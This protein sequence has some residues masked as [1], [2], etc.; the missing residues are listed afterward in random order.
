MRPIARMR[1]AL[2]AIG[3]AGL[4]ACTVFFAVLSRDQPLPF[5][6][7]PRYWVAIIGMSVF[8]LGGVCAAL[9]S[10]VP[11]RDAVLRTGVFAMLSGAL[12]TAAASAVFMLRLSD[13]EVGGTFWSLASLVCLGS[14]SL[15]GLPAAALL[16]YFCARGFPHRPFWSLGAGAFGLVAFGALPVSISCGDHSIYHVV[17][18]H[19]FA[20]LSAGV[21]S[22]LGL[23]ALYRALRARGVGGAEAR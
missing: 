21:V 14:A 11:G 15:V 13:G 7:E 6:P 22:W 23:W 12:I 3:L 8:A 16:T 18:A 1:S 10:S 17:F 5:V 19:L 2:A 4:G 9:G 20:P